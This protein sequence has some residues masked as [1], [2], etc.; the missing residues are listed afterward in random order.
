M[1]RPPHR[2]KTAANV[3]ALYD[4]AGGHAPF[5]H[6]HGRAGGGGEGVH[7]VCM[8]AGQEGVHDLHRRGRAGEGGEGV[9]Q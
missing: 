2:A 4:G 8:D 1:A 3:S 5:T 6:G 9:Y 7:Q